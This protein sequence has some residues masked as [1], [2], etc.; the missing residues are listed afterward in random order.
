MQKPNRTLLIFH[1]GFM[2]FKN[3]S[4]FLIF[5]LIFSPAFISIAA[6]KEKAA[7]P[8]AGVLAGTP[9]S[10]S[11]ETM[12]LKGT[13]ADISGKFK[14]PLPLPG[15]S[16][17]STFTLSC[18]GSTVTGQI[19]SPYNPDQSCEIY[20]GT[21]TGNKFTFSAKVGKT[22]YNFEGTAGEGKLSMTLTTRETIPLGD[23]TKIKTTQ[24]AAIDGAYLVPVYSPGGIMENIFFLKTE[25]NTLTGQMIMIRNPLKDTSTF[26]DGTIKGNE[27]S[28]Y[29][30]TPQSLFHFVGTIEAE[31][32]K[33]TLFVTDVKKNIEG[34]KI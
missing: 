24:E 32:I 2:K 33:L 31:K 8:P 20:N 3:A 30:R 10:T 26:F 11:T 12:I 21:A 14:V 19:T 4:L 23:G 6:A 13:S 18:K 27:V 34:G 29:T 1:G 15:G 7:G 9:G 17:D 16:K 25:G 22:E 5:V 28:F